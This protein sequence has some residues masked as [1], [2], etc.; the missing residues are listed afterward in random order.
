[1]KCTFLSDLPKII[2]GVL[3]SNESSKNIDHSIIVNKNLPRP[4]I[5]SN[6]DCV[7]V[8]E[9]K[10]SV[11]KTDKKTCDFMEKPLKANKVI[12]FA[13]FLVL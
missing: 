5:I 10:D 11:I 2:D 3:I 9:P 8:P 7:K 12:N 13:W 1:M 4:D 6:T